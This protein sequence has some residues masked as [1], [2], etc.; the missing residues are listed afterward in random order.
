MA[1]TA[2]PTR[3]LRTRSRWVLDYLG[4]ACLGM[5]VAMSP[6]LL[7]GHAFFS[8]AG[9]SMVK[10]FAAPDAELDP[11]YMSLAGRPGW[12]A[13]SA[14]VL[15]LARTGRLAL[16]VRLPSAQKVHCGLPGRG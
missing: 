4:S 11:L 8:S 10:Q 6:L 16:P 9:V 2:L 13:M 7:V 3:P 14:L 15:H 1:T 12:L 5:W